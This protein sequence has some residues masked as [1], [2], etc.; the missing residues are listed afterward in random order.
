MRCHP[1][2]VGSNPPSDPVTMAKCSGMV[3]V[4][5][6]KYMKSTTWAILGVKNAAYSILPFNSS[7]MKVNFQMCHFQFQIDFILKRNQQNQKNPISSMWAM[8]KGRVEVRT[9][10]L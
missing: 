1:Y 3:A 4:V 5:D 7:K 8:L 9:K 2:V 6:A 10:P